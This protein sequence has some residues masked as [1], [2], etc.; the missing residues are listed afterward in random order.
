MADPTTTN[1]GLTKPT[2]GADP[3]TWGGLL[4]TNFDTIDAAMFN[5]AV[6]GLRN[7]IINGDMSVDQRNSGNSFT[8][9]TAGGYTLDRWIGITTGASVTGQRVAG[10]GTSRYRYQVTGAASVTG[11][12]L[13]QRIEMMNSFDLAGQ[14]VTLSAEL[15]NSLLTSV[16][17]T[18]YYAS[19]DD[20][21]GTKTQI[22]T[23]TFTVNSTVTKYSTQISVPSAAT[24]GIEIDLSVGAQTSGT[25]TVGNVQLETG[26]IA[27]AFERRGATVETALCQR[28]YAT[29]AANQTFQGVYLG[30]TTRFPVLM[31][32]TPTM[33]YSDS[34]GTANTISTS[35]SNGVTPSAGS[36]V[37]AP[38][39]G[40][41]WCD[42]NIASS[43]PTWGRF[44][45]FATAEL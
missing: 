9:S 41:F 33:S 7:R 11:V 31:R 12:S 40:Q 45:W 37:S 14:T 15:A 4:N 21:F 39:I 17:W 25:W 20:N 18:A 36:P 29:G 30:S 3:D 8:I 27:T 44:N 26:S 38:S 2:V 6:A 32:A 13:A 16:T 42:L 23:G 43:G 22:A 35:A 34:V 28:Y 5:G 10:S 24:H 19:A 1:Y